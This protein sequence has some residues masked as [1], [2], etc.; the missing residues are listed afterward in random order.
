MTLTDK[1]KELIKFYL[2]EINKANEFNDKDYWRV[3]LRKIDNM[4]RELKIQ[5]IADLCEYW[6]SE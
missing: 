1:D 6:E 3:T 2:E 4:P 5:M